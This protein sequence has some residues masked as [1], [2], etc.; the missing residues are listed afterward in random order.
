LIFNDLEMDNRFLMIKRWTMGLN[1]IK[2]WTIGFW[3]FRDGRPSVRM[4]L[5]KAFSE[6]GFT[7]FTNFESRKGKE[8]VC[9]SQPAVNR[10]I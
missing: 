5:L 3:W 2:R 7:F 9:I 1:M 8:L 4:V 10:Y 6:N